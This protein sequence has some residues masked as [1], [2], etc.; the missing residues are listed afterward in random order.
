MTIRSY[1]DADV[2]GK[3][4]LVRVDF[5]V[6][7]AGGEI[8]DDTRIRAALPTISD[9]ID[10]GAAVVLISHLGRPKGE[11]NPKYSLAPVAE[12]LQSLLGRTVA[13]VP[14]IVGASA[15]E[16]ANSL[17]PGNLLLLE[18]LRF[19][20]GEEQNDPA[21]AKR[22]AS[23]A[24][25]FV[26][27]AFGAAHRAHAS[28]E[29]VA[30]LIPSFAGALMLAEIEALQRIVESP[31]EGFV[32]IIGGAKVSDKIT[33][34]E[35][36]VPKVETLLIG[37]G[38]AN[39]FLLEQRIEIGKSLAEPE[40]VGEARRVLELAS[41]SGTRVRLPVDAVVA[42]DINSTEPETVSV[43]EVTPAQS[44]FDI[45]PATIADFS[46]RIGEAAT[47]FWNGPMGVFERPAFATGTT[48]I[49]RV[50][51]DSGAYSVIGGGDSV[52]AVEAAGVA[53]KISHISTGGGASLEFVEGRKLPGIE[54]L[55]DR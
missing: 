28:T 48:E 39:T 5:N 3:R 20:M 43:S 51:A 26:N 11:R 13:F 8:R 4:V 42:L 9:L 47:I 32:A 18:N 15:Q 31:R 55:M 30:R 27:D 50:V 7:L 34:L 2:A 38:M 41:T 6:P 37:G 35:H 23:L 17:E 25:V 45:G 52:A 29:G 53:D 21:L 54:V 22:L 36:L 49:A 46:N 16:A 19:E 10:R 14:D 40:S 24:D 1:R 33:V 12:R 44:I